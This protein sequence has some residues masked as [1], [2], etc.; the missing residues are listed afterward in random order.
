MWN[1]LGSSDSL[2]EPTHPR[3]LPGGEQASVRVLSVP[4]LGGVRGGFMV[5]MHAQKR[6]EAFHEPTGSG[7][8]VPPA[9]GASRPTVRRGRDARAG[10]RDGCPTTANHRFMV[11]TQTQN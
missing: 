2:H 1:V 3:P 4:L 9:I 6:K 7:A 5:A 10:S 8:G 11:P